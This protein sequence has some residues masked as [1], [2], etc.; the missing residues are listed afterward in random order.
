MNKALVIIPTYNEK[1][2]VRGIVTAVLEQARARYGPAF[3]DVLRTCRIW[4]NGE[5]VDADHPVGDD[6]EIAVLPPVSGGF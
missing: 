5:E 1:E 4:C 3:G 6:D 2:N